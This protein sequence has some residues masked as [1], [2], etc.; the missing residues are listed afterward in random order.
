VA[1]LGGAE[2]PDMAA[3]PAMATAEPSQH[4]DRPPGGGIDQ[5]GPVDMPAAQREIVHAD[6]LRRGH[7]ARVG[8]GHDQAQQRAAVDGDAQR[9]GEPGTGPAGQLQGK[10]GQ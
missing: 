9:R 10:L 6:D 5:D 7:H 8:Q 1:A 2:G 4:V 3:E